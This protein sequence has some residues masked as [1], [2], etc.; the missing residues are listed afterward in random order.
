MRANQTV[1]RLYLGGD[2]AK[3]GERLDAVAVAQVVAQYFHGFTTIPA[4]GYW[5]GQGEDSW[6]IEIATAEFKDAVQVL[7]EELRRR[8]KQD[9]VGLATGGTFVTV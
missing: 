7:V 3:G 9:A 5:E 4:R 2:N 1:Y 8:F 6:V